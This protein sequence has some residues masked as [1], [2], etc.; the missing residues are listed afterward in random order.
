MISDIHVSLNATPT[1]M[2]S[3]LHMLKDHINTYGCTISS[4]QGKQ[5]S[6]AD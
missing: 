4:A 1:N 5:S 2:H 6:N 3:Y